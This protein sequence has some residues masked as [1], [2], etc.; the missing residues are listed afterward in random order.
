M[1]DAELR[2]LLEDAFP[3]EQA[4]Y[5]T[6]MTIGSTPSAADSGAAAI[7]NGT[8]TATSSP[9]WDYPDGKIPFV[10]AL[11]ILLDGQRRA[12]AIVETKRVEIIH[13]GSLDEEFARAYG[14]GDRTLDWWRS[15]MGAWYQASA[16]RHGEELSDET[17]IICE[18]IAVARRL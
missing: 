6:P 9:F 11:S 17:P 13:F 2:V 1:T 10:G 8:K 5:F 4:R 14:E 15:E 7:M 3:G 16:T 18:W 12:L